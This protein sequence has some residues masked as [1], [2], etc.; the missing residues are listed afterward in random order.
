MFSSRKVCE[1][2]GRRAEQQIYAILRAHSSVDFENMR[3][4]CATFHLKTQS[5]LAAAELT[6]S[7]GKIYFCFTFDS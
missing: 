3:S 6:I 4:K 2:T 5:I 1:T 7:Q